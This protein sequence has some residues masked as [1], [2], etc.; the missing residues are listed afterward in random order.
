MTLTIRPTAEI[1][2]LPTGTQV[3][4]WEGRTAGGARCVV[5]V[6]A[7]AVPPDQDSREFDAALVSIPNPGLHHPAHN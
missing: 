3:R 2:T 6:A 7:I 4:A 5:Y 1:L